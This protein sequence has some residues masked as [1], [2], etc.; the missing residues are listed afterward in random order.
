VREYKNA[1]TVTLTRKPVLKI[2]MDSEQITTCVGKILYVV[3]GTPKGVKQ[4]KAL[5]ALGLPVEP[6]KFT[7]VEAYRTTQMQ[8]GCK[9]NHSD[10]WVKSVTKALVQA[11]L[12]TNSTGF[13]LLLETVEERANVLRAANWLQGFPG[14]AH[15][16][17]LAQLGCTTPASDPTV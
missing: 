10:G 3:K 4:R 12:L 14:E 2:C 1:D 15:Q 11:K 7:I 8:R 9:V 13:K 5:Q 16:A 6:Q 17:L